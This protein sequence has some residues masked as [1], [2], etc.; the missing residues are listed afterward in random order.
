MRQ[1]CF[2]PE[3]ILRT[4]PF[5]ER[6]D[7][8]PKRPRE[9][10]LTRVSAPVSRAPVVCNCCASP[11]LTRGDWLS[12]VVQFADHALGAQSIDRVAGGRRE[13]SGRPAA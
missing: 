13:F 8:D 9:V 6:H 4:E 5:P 3:M 12:P 2:I 1:R 11:A 7:E 10:A